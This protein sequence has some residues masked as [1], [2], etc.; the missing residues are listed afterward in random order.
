[1]HDFIILITRTKE[2]TKSEIEPMTCMTISF[3][4]LGQKSTPN[5]K[6]F[7][8]LNNRQHA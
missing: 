1:M 5:G 2:H 4:L 6:P 7:L 3:L 8:K